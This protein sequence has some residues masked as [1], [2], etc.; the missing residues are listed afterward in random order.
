MANEKKVLGVLLDVNYEDTD[1]FSQIKIFVKEKKESRW[2]YDRNFPPY[3]YI[4]PI[5]VAQIKDLR[6]KVFE[7]TENFSI[8]DLVETKKEIHGKQVW[9]CSFAKVSEIVQARKQ[10]NEMGVQKFEYDIPFTKRYLID[11]EVFPGCV[12]LTV[13]GDEVKAIKNV[14]AEMDLVNG[15]FDL[16]TWSGDKFEVGREPI[17]MASIVSGKKGEVYSYDTKKVEG[18]GLVDDEEEL[19]KKIEEEINK[20]DLIVTYNG[21]NFD[22]P[23]VKK[24]GEKFKQ[25]FLVNGAKIRIKR[26]GLDNAAAIKGKQ[27]IDAY[28]IMKFMQR[29]GSVNIVKLDLENV[30]DKIFGIKK[31]KV[32]PHEI[33][34]AWEGKNKKDLERLVNYNLED[35][36]TTLR[37]AEDFLPLFVELSKLTSQTLEDVTRSSTSQKVEDLLLKEAYKRGTIAPNKAHEGEI[38]ERLNRSLKGAFVKEPLAGLHENIAVLDFASLYPSLIILHNISP[39]TLNCSHA[40]C[41]KNKSPDGTW[42]CLKEKGLVPEILEKML[43]QRLQLKKEYKDKKK[44]GVDDKVLF[45]KQWALKIIMNSAFGYLG[46]ARARWY[47]FEAASA[48]LAWARDY[49]HKTI[50]KAEQ[51]GYEVLYGDTDSTFLLMKDKNKK[52]VEKFVD[53]VNNALSGDMELE[54]DGYYKRGIFVTKKEGGAA[55]KRYA[56]I[57]EKNNLKIVG[58]EY[59]RRDWCNLAKE[60]QRRVIELV[61][62]E[63]KPEKAV[64]L[65]REVIKEL[66]SGKVKKTELS[67]I[68]MLK[69]K[70]EDYSSTGPHVEAAKK[71]LAKGKDVGV[72]SLLSFIITKNGKTI[73]EKAVL[74]EY[75]S[76]G[77]YDADYYIN[78]QVLPAVIKIMR[79]LGYT[80]EDL[81]HGGKQSGLGAWM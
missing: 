57:D 44:K 10:L 18:L 53:K 81:I 45:A 79:E 36:R 50:E 28:Q 49:I 16:E 15:A 40:E 21:D 19:L 1:E 13:E 8:L 80:E 9:K 78:N 34:S 11:K 64:E 47:S 72:G 67:I 5:N 55:K 56:L 30:S 26:R 35:S 65:V 42:F 58:F 76:E 31:E 71:A 46:Y 7:G 29:T 68:T 33:N 52:D 23:Y 2:Y 77:D 59:V 20:F 51:E 75:V 74:D 70:I 73:S 63:G 66:K 3:L 17:I 41:K 61:L 25:D 4:T 69:R 22:F 27:H 24:R 43:K 38:R 14:D 12:E 60:T 6:E 62:A 54:V 48:I 37:I 32:Y 39:E